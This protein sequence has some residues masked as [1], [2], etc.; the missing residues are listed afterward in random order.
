M[1]INNEAS[2]ATNLLRLQL[3]NLRKSKHMTQKELAEKANLSINTISEIENIN[4]GNNFTIHSVM[5][6]IVAL[7]SEIYLKPINVED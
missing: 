6:Y 5:K 7:E 4:T 2:V 1:N 3:S